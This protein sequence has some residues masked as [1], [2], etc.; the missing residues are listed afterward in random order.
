MSHVNL[1]KLGNVEM[2]I[3]SC[4]KRFE[5]TWREITASDNL[6][7]KILLICDK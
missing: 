7:T 3:I 6:E 5:F 4:K 1:I 2:L